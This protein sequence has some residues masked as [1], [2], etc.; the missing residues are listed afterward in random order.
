MIDENG[1]NQKI[2]KIFKEV[3]PELKNT[4]FNLNKTQDQF[5]EWDS[6]SHMQLVSKIEQEFSISLEIEEVIEADSALK[7]IEIIK[8]KIINNG[9]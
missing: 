7:F 2:K 8:K 4:D 6:F 3:F 1:I 9:A 5:E